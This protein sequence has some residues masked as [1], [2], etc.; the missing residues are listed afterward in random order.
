MNLKFVFC[1]I[2]LVSLFFLQNL[3]FSDTILLEI[4]EKNRFYSDSIRGSIFFQVEFR[5]VTF[6]SFQIGFLV[7][8]PVFC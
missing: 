6:V 5:S 2:F 3:I 8:E 4:E 1:L 7:S